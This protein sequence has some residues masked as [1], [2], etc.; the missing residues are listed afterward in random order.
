M[1]NPYGQTNPYV[2]TNDNTATLNLAGNSDNPYA[3]NSA[4]PTY[5]AY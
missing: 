2:S 5:P 1:Q 4:Y 3:N